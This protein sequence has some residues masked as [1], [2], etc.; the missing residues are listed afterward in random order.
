MK[1]IAI[2]ENHLYHKTFQRGKRWSG[3][4]VTV[5]VLK[6]LAAKRLKKANPQKQ[7]INRIG[8]S[9]PKREGGA[10]ERNR[11]KRILREGLRAVEKEQPLRK[12]FLV[13][14]ST[15]KGIETQKSTAIARDLRF[16]FKKLDMLAPPPTMSSSVPTE[17]T[18]PYD[19]HEG[20]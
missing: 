5:C 15:R 13:V 8:L 16:V 6:D 17:A 2:T 11:V 4:Y 12:G 7:Y 18:V 14:I 3:R 20:S 9:V 10:I 19:G 1:E